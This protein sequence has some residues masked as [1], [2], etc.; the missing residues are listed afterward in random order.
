M[1]TYKPKYARKALWRE[2]PGQ[3]AN[4]TEPKIIRVRISRVSRV[5][6]K[7]LRKYHARVRVWKAGKMCVGAGMTFEGKPICCSREH[8]C[9]HVHHQRGRLAG[10]LMD[11]RFWIPCCSQLHSFIHDNPKLAADWK[12]TDLDNWNKLPKEFNA[13][14]FDA[15]LAEADE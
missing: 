15:D 13:A 11:E 4:L 14:Q 5:M 8:L 10:L 12:L 1:L 2:L 3:R 6:S 7:R 9:D